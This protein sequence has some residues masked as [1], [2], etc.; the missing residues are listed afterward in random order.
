ME[1]PEALRAEIVGGNC[2]AFVGAGFSAPLVPE[3]PA[4]LR[5]L[6]EDLGESAM[7]ERVLG[8]DARPRSDALEAAAQ[9]LRDAHPEPFLEALRQRLGHEA[10]ATAVTPGGR[11]ARR[12]EL[13]RSVPFATILT[14][15]FDGL[16]RGRTPDGGAYW[17]ALRPQAHRW[18][19]ARFWDREHLGP[20]V[21]K[22]HGDV[23]AETA[24]A[25]VFSKRDYRQRL[26]S[27]ASY[28]SFLR[29]MMA[30]FTVLYLGF[31]FTDAYVNELRSEVLSI[32]GDHAHAP[33]AYAVLPNVPEDYRAYLRSHE[34]IQVLPY[35]HERGDEHQG[36]DRWLA[37]VH[38]ETN[39]I[40]LLGRRL[41]GKRILW[42]DAKP[43]NNEYAERFLR[44]AAA[45]APGADCRI[46]KVKTWQ[47]ACAALESQRYDLVMTHWGWR[48]A[49]LPSG[50]PAAAG[51]RL[52]M[53]MRA[54]DLRAPVLVLSTSDF[55][56]ENR[57]V[58]LRL[59]AKEYL[60]DWSELFREVAELFA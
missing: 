42:N 45:D 14:T 26:Y 38:A 16:L 15:N 30:R 10:L 58:A 20:Q 37:A 55:A 56:P 50:E 12:L 17:G 47:A 40:Q 54:R 13:L 49:A 52:L 57:P 36:F 41:S 24:D 22:L 11:M 51:E 29:A 59:G 25:L 28:R 32:F 48:K 31:S 35:A 39:P 9:M 60:C 2:V 7:V 4:L 6:G 46:D 43:I 3:W 18:W 34:G 53:E 44:E 27:L 21:V 23:D 33:I 1:V 19:E 8:A 5:R